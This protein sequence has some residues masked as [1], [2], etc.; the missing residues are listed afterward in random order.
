[1]YD[2]L[3]ATELIIIFRLFE[4]QSRKRHTLTGG[5]EMDSHF[6]KIKGRITTVRAL[7][8]KTRNDSFLGLKFG[9]DVPISKRSTKEFYYF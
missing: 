4:Y 9:M 6:L 1:M 3:V 5:L 8:E 2:Q 7:I